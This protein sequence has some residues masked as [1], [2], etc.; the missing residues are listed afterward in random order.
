MATKKERGEAKTH[1]RSP[2][3]DLE[4]EWDRRLA[5]LQAADAGKRLDAVMAAKGRVKRRR[6]KAG[7]TF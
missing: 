1:R 4:A 7:P 3:A 5:P 6:S 2:R